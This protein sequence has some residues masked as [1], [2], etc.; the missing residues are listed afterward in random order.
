MKREKNNNL[1][2]AWQGRK[3]CTHMHTHTLMHEHTYTHKP[4]PNT[5][6]ISQEMSVIGH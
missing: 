6:K 2:Q 3:T 4:L 1:T 5:R